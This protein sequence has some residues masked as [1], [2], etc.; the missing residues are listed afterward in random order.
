MKKLKNAVLI[1]LSLALVF[2]PV[3]AVIGTVLFTSP[4]YSDTFYGAL[5][6]K[7]DRL[8]STEEDKI[9]VVG[10]SSVAFGLDSALLESELGMPVVNFGL[11]AAIGTKAMLDLSRAGVG[12]GD[13]VILAPELDAQ[14]LSLYFSAKNMLMSLDDDYSM[15]R[16]IRGDNILSLVGASFEHASAKL[17]YNLTEKPS[18]T[19]IYCSASFNE[20]GDIKYGL[21]SQN[22]MPLYYEASNSIE[23]VPEILS[24]DFAHYVNEYI[25]FCES[26]GATVYFSYC[27]MNAMGIKGSPTK[28]ELA[29]FTG[30]LKS[31]IDCE[32][33]S[34]IEDYIMDAGYFYDTN[35]HLN[36]AGVIKRTA[37]LAEDLLIALD[38]WETIE[39][40]V[41]EAPPLPESDTRYFGDED[42]NAVYFTYE[43]AA[44][45]AM[46]ITG[47]TEL[48]KEQKSL[49]VPLGVD[50]Y[51]VVYIGASAFSEGVAKT[52]T[53]TEDTSLRGFLDD[54]F[55][56][57]R[58]TDV[59]I[60]YNFKDE[61]GVTNEEEK[62]TPASYMYNVTIHIPPDSPYCTGG[63]YDWNDS[64]GGIK[65]RVT[66]A[67]K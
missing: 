11:Y 3:I 25:D 22:I 7:F 4:V 20:Y 1:F 39:I 27:P 60:Y 18:P 59:W 30:Y 5:D 58:I 56:D 49:T 36:D 53:V 37:T 38:R 2:L 6:E 10:G 35:Y 34:R 32:F 9:I 66:D 31:Q 29:E 65:N 24:H 16:Y 45:G 62:L 47:L 12:E 55:K 57:S 21:R 67:V 44:N 50:G 61:N 52:L 33:I 15:L 43:Q 23:L 19:G 63:H 40:T 46:I 17:K 42:P 51:K 54:C 26:K 41:P 48:G 28:N 8:T 13:I 64:T 14:T